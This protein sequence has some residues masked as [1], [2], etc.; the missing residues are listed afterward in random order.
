MGLNSYGA[1]GWSSFPTWLWDSKASVLQIRLSRD[2]GRIWL[3]PI[4]SSRGPYG[5]EEGSEGH[6]LVQD[7]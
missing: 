1:Y 3:L 7:L 2:G 6:R 5:K 4:R